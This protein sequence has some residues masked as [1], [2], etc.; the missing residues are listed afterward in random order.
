MLSLHVEVPGDENIFKLHELIEHIESDLDGVL[1]C[2]SVIHMD[3]L[4]QRMRLLLPCG[5]KFQSW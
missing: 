3:Q 1:N 2:E 5:R 4:K